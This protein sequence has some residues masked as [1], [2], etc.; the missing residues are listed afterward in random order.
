MSWEQKQPKRETTL[1][2]LTRQAKAINR[3]ML[4]HNKAVE[5]EEDKLLK[6]IQRLREKNQETTK[7]T[8]R[9]QE[10]HDNLEDC[11][12]GYD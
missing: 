8:L 6:A 4:N 5:Q 2:R 12:V 1:V 9:L 7:A 10:L 3:L 11:T